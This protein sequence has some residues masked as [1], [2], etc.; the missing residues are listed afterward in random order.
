MVAAHSPAQ[1]SAP[2]R[3]SLTRRLMGVAWRI[4]VH[5]SSA[6]AGREAIAAGFGEVERIERILS[7]Y[8]L[9]S[10][11]SRLSA[12]SPSGGPVPVGEDLWRALSRSVE[13]RDA[14]DGAFDPTVGPLTTLWRRTGRDRIRVS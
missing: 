14:T 10:E 9:K 2:V 1:D 11:L 4:T 8:D 6:E 7:D 5:A 3:V 13:I 12:A